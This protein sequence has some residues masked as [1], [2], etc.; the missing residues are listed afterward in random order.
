MSDQCASPPASTTG[1]RRRRLWNLPALCHCP[2]VGVCFS[3]PALR[4]LVNKALGGKAVADDY[5][6]HVGAVAQCTQ[7][8]RL[9]E[10]LQKDLESRY[11][12][13][14]QGFRAARD[15]PAVADLWAAAL[16]K[17]DVAGAFWATLTL[18]LIHI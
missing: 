11:A 2:V 15:T 6:V 17:A 1:S 9:S 14:V 3:L 10:L 8:N 12:S 4:Q 16:R 7:R 5:D 18:S 13:T